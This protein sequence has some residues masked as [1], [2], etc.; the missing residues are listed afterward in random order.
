M[1]C[2]KCPNNATLEIRH[3]HTGEIKYFCDECGGIFLFIKDH[4]KIRKLG[5][6]IISTGKKLIIEATPAKKIKIRDKPG[7]LGTTNLLMSETPK[8]IRSKK[9]A[10]LYTKAVPTLAEAT[11]QNNHNISTNVNNTSKIK[12]AL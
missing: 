12:K 9:T 5:R 7:K 8:K 3:P 4:W 1:K 10:P 2:C 6:T 11:P